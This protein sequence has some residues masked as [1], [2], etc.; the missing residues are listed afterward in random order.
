M[1]QFNQM[2]STDH[3]GLVLVLVGALVHIQT[4]DLKYFST[5]VAKLRMIMMTTIKLMTMM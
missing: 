4:N 1:L 2:H 5:C 3:C